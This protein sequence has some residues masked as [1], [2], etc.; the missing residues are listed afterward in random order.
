LP[1]RTL[2]GKA[3]ITIKLGIMLATAHVFMV[4]LD[5]PNM[6]EKVILLHSKSEKV[7]PPLGSVP[8]PVV[9]ALPLH[10]HS[11]WSYSAEGFTAYGIHSTCVCK[12]MWQLR[13]ACM[14]YT[15]PAPRCAIRLNTLGVCD[16]NLQLYCYILS[17]ILQQA[18]RS[19]V[20]SKL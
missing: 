4:L 1:I 7:G 16:T 11:P 19:R 3:N 17:M 13:C 8:S 20:T 15:L 9:V 10:E 14:H 18:C 5:E 6:K 12:S 2:F